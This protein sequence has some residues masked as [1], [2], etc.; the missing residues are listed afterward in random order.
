[1]NPPT[2]RPTKIWIV[3]LGRYQGRLSF[4]A[5][6]AARFIS[7]RSQPQITQIDTDLGK[8]LDR[9]VS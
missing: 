5:V 8:L 4:G 6:V 3:R 7:K 2:M 9:F 1:M